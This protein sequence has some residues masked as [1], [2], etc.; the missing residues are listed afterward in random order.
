M[1]DATDKRMHEHFI[2]AWFTFAIL[3]I[4]NPAR[5]SDNEF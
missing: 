2:S 4:V 3:G 1:F 5:L